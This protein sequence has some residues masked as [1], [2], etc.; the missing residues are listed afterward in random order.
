MQL[1]I[2]NSAL[3]KWRRTASFKQKEIIKLLGL[4]GKT[5]MSRLERGEGY[6]G[7][8]M[9]IALEVLT[10]MPL[11]TLLA[12]LYEV[13]EEETLARVTEMLMAMEDSPSKITMNKCRHLRSCQ[14]RVITRH[15]Q[16]PHAQTQKE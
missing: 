10:G 9:A 14:D 11:H 15:K 12:P 5:H 4:K 8:C 3:R 13:V 16:K 6:P 2:K 7:L 1:P